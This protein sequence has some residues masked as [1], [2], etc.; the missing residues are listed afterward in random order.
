M[1]LSENSQAILLLTAHFTERKNES[2][3]PL[4]TTEWGRFAA[5]LK[6]QQLNPSSLN[7]HN[8]DE[9]L[10][11]WKDKSITTDRLG[12]LF[13][14]GNAL[15]LAVEKWQRA[16]LWI[17]T[18]SDTDYPRFL[19]QRLKS[20]SPPVLFG[21][22]NRDSLNSGGLAVVGSRK[23]NPQDLHFSRTIGALAASKGVQVISGGAKGVDES[24][25]LEALKNG[26]KVI[27]VVAERLMKVIRSLK[28]RP[29]LE[30]GR[31]VIVSPFNP[32]SGFS[33][34]QAMDRNKLIYC[35]SNVGFVIQSE[36]KGGTWSGANENLKK[37]WVPLWVRRTTEKGSGNEKIFEAGARWASNN[38]D[39]IDID[40]LINTEW[41]SRILET[42]LFQEPASVGEERR[43][44]YEENRTD[45]FYDL[46]L[47][48]VHY[49]CKDDAKSLAELAKILPIQSSQLKTWLKR[50]TEE[51]KLSKTSRPVMYHWS[52]Q[53]K[54]PLPPT[55]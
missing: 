22:G 11:G 28:Y 54:L 20:A 18:R 47:A 1:S 39:D 7:A 16:G 42:G 15:A 41:K 50:A 26:G 12:A 51:G 14:R 13:R 33:V 46:F 48:K 34:R 30:D 4:S 35:L 6:G 55:P 43:E 45:E 40:D 23:A 10:T 3:R 52:D 49:H 27:G 9:L 32:D 38:V 37:N 17:M 19:K 36:T 5:W 2:V 21:C 29:Y 8:L 31:L 24:A 44:D 25:M 53:S